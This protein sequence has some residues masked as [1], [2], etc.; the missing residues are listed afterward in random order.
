MRVD[1]QELA[2]L[3]HGFATL[4]A[5]FPEV[6]TLADDLGRFLRDAST[7]K[8]AAAPATRLASAV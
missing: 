3:F 7:A 5:L 1:Y 4:G 8:S 6:A 2:H